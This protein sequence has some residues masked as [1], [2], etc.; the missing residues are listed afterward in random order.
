MGILLRPQKQPAGQ[1]DQGRAGAHGG[2]I[3]AQPQRQRTDV[4][5]TAAAQGV[6]DGAGYR[7][8]RG[9]PQRDG[10]VGLRIAEH[11]FRPGHRC[12]HIAHS[13]RVK[14]VA[15]VAAEDLLA[16]EHTGQHRRHQHI[17]VHG[18]RHEQGDDKAEALV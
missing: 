10:S 18:D 17:D 6:L 5:H 8:R 9:V 16:D 2:G 1:N 4:Q 15:A 3:F 11:L 13:G 14:G 7:H 12:H